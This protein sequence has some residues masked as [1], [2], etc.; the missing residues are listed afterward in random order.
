[1]LLGNSKSMITVSETK[2]KGYLPPDNNNSIFGDYLFMK[3]TTK[4]FLSVLISI[5]VIIFLYI[6]TTDSIKGPELA[7]EST[8]TS[9][10]AS[11]VINNEDLAGTSTTKQFKF[12]DGFDY[13]K[14]SFKNTG[15]QP[16]TFTIN[17]GSTTGAAKMSGTV[18]ADG[19]E[20]TFYSEKAWPTGEF[21]LNISSAH[22]MT[23]KLSLH[24]GNDLSIQ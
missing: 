1:M 6:Y 11:T 23:G 16:I 24:L 2:S 5:G 9:L 22:G 18:S 8:T 7:D 10:P 12:P 15:S 13:V 4:I 3:N 21:Y 20:H 17:Q 19:K 14:V